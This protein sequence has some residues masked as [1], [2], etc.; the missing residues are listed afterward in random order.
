MKGTHFDM[1]VRLCE[2][3]F[4]RFLGEGGSD[5]LYNVEYTLCFHIQQS[6][7]FIT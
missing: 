7:Y 3:N 4:V 1:Q 6:I 2:E 5:V